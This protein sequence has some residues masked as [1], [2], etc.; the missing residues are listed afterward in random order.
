[1]YVHDVRGHE[2]VVRG[3]DDITPDVYMKMSK[4]KPK[5]VSD[6]NNLTFTCIAKDRNIG[7]GRFRNTFV[8]TSDRKYPSHLEYLGKCREFKYPENEKIYE[9]FTGVL[10]WHSIVEKA[11]YSYENELERQAIVEVLKNKE[12]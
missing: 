1:M 7:I 10:A 2:F 3:V 12:V 5:D 8:E 4:E 9:P 11:I 6:I